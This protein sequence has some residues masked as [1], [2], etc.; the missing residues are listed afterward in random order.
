MEGQKMSSEC[1]AAP[2]ISE[3]DENKRH[4]HSLSGFLAPVRNFAKDFCMCEGNSS[5]PHVWWTAIILWFLEN[6][7][8]EPRAL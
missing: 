5:E 7:E 3:S 1:V 2:V 6:V 8:S 4:Y